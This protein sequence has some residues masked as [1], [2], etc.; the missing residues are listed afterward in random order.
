[1]VLLVLAL[2]GHPESGALWDAVL[3]KVLRT[4]GW[5]TAEEWPGV[6][7]HNDGSV[8]VVYVDDLLLCALRL[9]QEE[10]S[11]DQGSWQRATMS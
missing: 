5:H 3:E 4:R 11:D 1:M 8:L 2:Y 6:W 10:L 9:K 7:V